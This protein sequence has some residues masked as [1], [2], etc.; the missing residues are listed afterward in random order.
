[1]Q[2]HIVVS[3]LSLTNSHK[4]KWAG[5]SVWYEHSTRDQNI[6]GLFSNAI[7]TITIDVFVNGPLYFN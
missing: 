3:E 6:A 4:K 7:V 5:I 2:L 1:M